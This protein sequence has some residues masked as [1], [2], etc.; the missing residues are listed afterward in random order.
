[1]RVPLAYTVSL[2]WPWQSRRPTLVPF[3]FQCAHVA[4]HQHPQRGGGCRKEGEAVQPV[5][6]VFGRAA[7][8]LYDLPAALSTADDSAPVQ[9]GL[10]THILLSV[11]VAIFRSYT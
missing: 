1:M 3:F 2:T 7:Q 9:R 8:D 4:V 5:A 6:S 10:V 11:I